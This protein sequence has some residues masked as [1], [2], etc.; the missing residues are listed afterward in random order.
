VTLT[1]VPPPH[2]DSELVEDREPE[3]PSA[4]DSADIEEGVLETLAVTKA[5]EVWLA[6]ATVSVLVSL[7]SSEVEELGVSAPRVEV[8]VVMVIVTVADEVEV[9]VESVVHWVVFQDL[10]NKGLLV[11]ALL[12][13]A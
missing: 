11:T 10:T 2:V 1:V 12:H 9:T 6:R 13:K 5:V 3:T 7:L 4:V 8:I